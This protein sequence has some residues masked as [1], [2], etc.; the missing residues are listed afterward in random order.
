M[1]P[2]AEIFYTRAREQE[3]PFPWDHLDVGVTR[4]FLWR[5]WEKSQ[6]G[7]TTASCYD[8]CSACGNERYRTGVCPGGDVFL[9]RAGHE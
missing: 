3:E 9:R 1:I 5:E 8:A 6:A 4:R 7:K 2:Q